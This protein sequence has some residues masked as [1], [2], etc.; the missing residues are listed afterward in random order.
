MFCLCC[1]FWI[2]ARIVNIR[3]INA[4]TALLGIGLP[5]SESEQHSDNNNK[6]DLLKHTREAFPQPGCSCC[7]SVR[8]RLASCGSSLSAQGAVCS[9]VGTAGTRVP[10]GDMGTGGGGGDSRWHPRAELAVGGIGGE[11][12]GASPQWVCF[13]WRSTPHGFDTV[14]CSAGCLCAGFPAPKMGK[15]HVCY[16]FQLSPL[17]NQ[18]KK[19]QQYYF[20]LIAFLT[21][22]SSPMQLLW[23]AVVGSTQKSYLMAARRFLR[24]VRHDAVRFPLLFVS[25]ILFYFFP[26]GWGLFCSFLFSSSK[27]R[28][29]L[30]L[31]IVHPR[32]SQE[33]SE[34]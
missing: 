27:D 21:L 31:L 3:A 9:P 1:H 33:G 20:T 16:L 22:K 17:T 23:P 18:M 12:L 26:E 28:L 15:S 19:N 8:G 29:Q 13:C 10:H 11:L 30:D 14:P 24:E 34:W 25:G 32:R 2:S 5:I 4:A 6:R 7:S